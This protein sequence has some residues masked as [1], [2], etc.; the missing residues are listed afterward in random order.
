MR[1]I[2]DTSVVLR[3][4]FGDDQ[5][6]NTW[7]DWEDAY[8]STLMAVEA[9]RRLSN[10]RLEG[11]YDDESIIPALSVLRE[12]LDNLTLVDLTAEIMARASEQFP[13]ILGTLDALHVATALA[14]SDAGIEDLVLATHDEQQGRAAGAL[15]LTVIGLKASS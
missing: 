1:V 6:L 11:L 5:R 9:Y 10:A 8:A 3:V 4:V 12:I 15:G 13:T 2:L 14:L 7:G